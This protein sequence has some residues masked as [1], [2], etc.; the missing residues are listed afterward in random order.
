MAAT[1][2][3]PLRTRFQDALRDAEHHA[4]ALA[5]ALRSDEALRARTEDAIR[6]AQLGLARVAE[7]FG[8]RERAPFAARRFLVVDDS[9]DMRFIVPRLVR[10]LHPG[11]SVQVARD[12]SEA[13]GLLQDARG[14]EGLVVISDH[15]MGAGPT[16]V[17]LLAEVARRHPGARRVLFTGR[18]AEEI[19]H[20]GAEPD[21]V[22]PKEVGMQGLRRFLAPGGGLAGPAEGSRVD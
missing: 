4:H 18:A 17:E 2:L 14:G 15:D 19:P 1:L 13:L 22:L 5:G 21:A 3:E 11:A 6:E 8:G 12:A 16:G 20:V 7:L 9:E 10:E